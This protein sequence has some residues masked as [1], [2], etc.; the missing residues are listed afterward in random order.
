[1]FSIQA[2]VATAAVVPLLGRASRVPRFG[3]LVYLL[4]NRA[5]RWLR[6]GRV[7]D[8]GTAL[9]SIGVVAVCGGDRGEGSCA[10]VVA[11]LDMEKLL[12]RSRTGRSILIEGCP[13]A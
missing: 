2:A 8:I 11:S 9:L 7:R 13:V 12:Y 3:R 1:M 6:D 10:T 4:D 5:I